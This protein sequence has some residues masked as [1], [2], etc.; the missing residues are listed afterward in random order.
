LT[1]RGLLGSDC[2]VA[3]IG[4]G[5]GRFAVAFAREARHVLGIDIS[6][7]MIQHGVVYAKRE[8]LDNVSFRVLDFQTADIDTENL[9][10]RFDLVFSSITPA[11]R[12]INGLEK[13]MRMSRKYCCNIMYIQ[14]DNE[15][16]RRIMREVFQRERSDPRAKHWQLFY[17]TFNALFLKGYYPE[18]TFHKRHLEKTIQFDLERVSLFIEQMLPLEER[19]IENERKIRDWVRANADTDADACASADADSDASADASGK[20]ME[21]SDIWYGRILW[22]VREKGSDR[23]NGLG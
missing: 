23:Y 7:R 8:N 10:G 6:E 9:H 15:L 4:C 2:D 17:S 3:D 19:S 16:E 13:M 22:D 20:M 1:N 12:G 14:S 11:I 5:P 21:I 18:V